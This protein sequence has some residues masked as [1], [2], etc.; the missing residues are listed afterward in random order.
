MKKSPLHDK[1]EKHIN[2]GI[3]IPSVKPIISL[4][5]CLKQGSQILFLS[6]CF[7]GNDVGNITYHTHATSW[8]IPPQR[9]E[10]WL[11]QILDINY[12]THCDIYIKQIQDKFILLVQ[13]ARTSHNL[14]NTITNKLV[15]GVSMKPRQL[16]ND[17]SSVFSHMCN[18]GERRI[19][20]QK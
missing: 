8:K 9:I 3:D 16:Q 2:M 5:F 14:N 20:Y 1:S 17:T 13:K 10:T 18:Y 19:A 15:K 12:S 7:G 6:K 4:T 11:H